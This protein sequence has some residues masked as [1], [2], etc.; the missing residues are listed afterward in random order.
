MTT[1][2]SYRELSVQELGSLASELRARAPRQEAGDEIDVSPV[3]LRTCYETMMRLSGPRDAVLD[4][5]AYLFAEE[6][7]GRDATVPAL[8]LEEAHVEPEEGLMSLVL[9]RGAYTP[10]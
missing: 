10:R 4:Y 3:P 2:T 8:A 9:S 1:M 6:A 7:K 5:A